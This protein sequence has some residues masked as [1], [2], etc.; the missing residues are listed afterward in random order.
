MDIDQELAYL[1]GLF[2]DKPRLAT[3][4]E[5]RGE[6]AQDWLDRL[7]L[8]VD[9]PHLSLP[10]QLCSSI[11]KV[12]IRLSKLS[13]LHPKCLS[14]HNVHKLG[15]HPIAAGGFGDVW[16]GVIGDSDS[17]G[18]IVCLKIVKV[19]LT[20][21]VQ[22]LF[23]E[24]LREAIVWRQLKHPNLLP[25]LGI[26]YLEDEISPWMEKG[27]L[28]QYL[29]ATEGENIDRL[30]LVY[31]VAAGLAYLH[32]KKIV[33]GDLKGVNILITPDGRAC[34][35]DFGLSRVAD[36]H[37]QLRLTTSTSRP[38]GTGRWL[39]PEILSAEAG[40]S[41]KSD[42]YAFGC[43]CYE[44]FTIRQPFYELPNE[45]AVAVQVLVNKR[46]PSR[47]KE[48]DSSELSSEMWSI[49]ERCWD[50]D[51]E[52]RPSAAWVVKQV[53]TMTRSDSE[54]VSGISPAPIWSDAT[55]AHIWDNIQHEDFPLTDSATPDHF[56]LT[57]DEY[58][59]LLHGFIK[60]DAVLL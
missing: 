2:E 34:I 33:H 21:D 51:P 60:Y 19:Y 24:Y 44:I 30:V 6:D 15:Q 45:M 37:A 26:Y 31:D 46:R 58:T 13:G 3:F 36:T 27:N 43:V 9:N 20:S 40:P 29:K 50:S 8:L 32:S 39:A 49:M 11:F 55:F 25:F 52:S 17:G 28:A 42:M 35:G 18:P 5:Q 48:T 23:K 7:Q 22:A 14:I 57:E 38:A 16:K 1:E 53:E 10:P 56:P 4:L 41:K 54:R 12:M 47:P 59:N